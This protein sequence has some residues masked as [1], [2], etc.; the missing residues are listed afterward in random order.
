MWIIIALISSNALPIGITL[1]TLKVKTTSFSQLYH[2]WFYFIS[3]TCNCITSNYLFCAG[4]GYGV[5]LPEK[6]HTGKWN[7]YRYDT[8]LFDCVFVIIYL[9]VVW[10]WQI[11]TFTSAACGYISWA[12]RYPDSSWQ[13]CVSKPYVFL[14][15]FQYN[16]K[17]RRP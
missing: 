16:N 17:K 13:F 11:C 12:T 9:T 15:L 7:V 14:F 5:V 4:Q 1:M 10:C 6:L 8:Y 3:A 2:T